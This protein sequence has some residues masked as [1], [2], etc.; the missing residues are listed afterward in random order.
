MHVPRWS[1]AAWWAIAATAAFVLLTLWWLTQDRGTPYG[2]ASEELTAAFQFHDL[3]LHGDVRG[4]LDYPAYYPPY[5]LMLGGMLAIVGGIGR[6]GVVLGNDLV[7]VP[8]LALACYRIGRRVAGSHAGALAVVFALGAPLVIELFHVFMIDTFEATL[9]AV[10][11]WLVLASER[12]SKPGPA[13]L[14]GVAVGIGIGTKEQFPLYLVGFLAVV[15]ARGG[16]RNA[17]GLGAFA[18]ISLLIAL[19]WYVHQGSRLRM[20]WRAA[21]NGEG[22]LFPVSPAARP[23]LLSS[24]ATEWYGWA[25]LNGLLFAPLTAFAV[26]GVAAAAW[27]V[28]RR[29]ERSSV[30][31][32]L[33]GGLIGSWLALTLMTHKDLRY[34]LP[35][36]VYLAV[37]G[38]AWIGGLRLRFRSLA[39]AG[40]VAAVIAT[41]LGATFGVGGAVPARLPGNLG[42]PQGI[43]VPPRDRVVVYANYDYLVSGPRRDGDLLPL[44]RGLRR[45]GIRKV[46]WDLDQ[47]TPENTNFNGVGLGALALMARL[48][49]PTVIARNLILPQY[50]LLLYQPAPRGTRPCVRFD[51]GM[52]VWALIAHG[53]LAVGY[54]PGRG[55]LGAPVQVPQISSTGSPATSLR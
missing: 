25:T 11:V 5:G 44:L 35:T 1:P 4:I 41:T 33:L 22:F 38:T 7:C 16:W 13:L 2:D 8:L 26:A 9:V 12:F 21:G 52:G 19:P 39:T 20:L 40:L 46:Y 45:I 42:A 29:R 37:L 17:R 18:G 28:W 32:E 50:S 43:G 23:A 3:L 36:I 6:I 49:V 55:V 31:P 51:D 14:A 15:L 54:C 24:A 30:V 47:A 27:R 34:T 53:G 48:A 10:S